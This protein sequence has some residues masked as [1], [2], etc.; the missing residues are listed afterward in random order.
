MVLFPL[1]IFSSLL[2][3][4]SATEKYVSVSFRDRIV[5]G[6]EEAV[7]GR[8][9]ETC[10]LNAGATAGDISCGCGRLFEGNADDMYRALCALTA[11][12]RPDDTALAELC[13]KWGRGGAAGQA[14]REGALWL[15][16]RLFRLAAK[17]AV[18]PADTNACEFEV[19]AIDRLTSTRSAPELATAHTDFLTAAGRME[20]LYM[21]FGLLLNRELSGLFRKTLP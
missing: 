6:R 14:G 3:R 11:E 7:G 10:F 12:A 8:E 2:L 18:S 19:A 1:T 21:D 20:S 13:D 9:G 15:V 4:E 5:R 17:H 16:G